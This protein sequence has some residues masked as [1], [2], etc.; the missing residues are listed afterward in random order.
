MEK[1]IGRSRSIA[2]AGKTLEA[3]FA[4]HRSGTGPGLLLLADEAGL[5]AGIRARAG[6][7]GEEGYAVL[8]V[9]GLSEAGEVRA[10][11]DALRAMPEQAGGIGVLGHGAGGAL[12]CR[13]ASAFDAAVAFDPVGL[14]EASEIGAA[15]PALLVFGT[16][17]SAEAEQAAGRI[18]RGLDRSDGSAVLRYPSAAPGFAI[19]HRAGFDKRSD[20]LAHSRALGLLRRALGPHYDLVA[21]FEA[22][23][24]HEFETRDVDATMATM[25]DEPYVNHVPTLAGG[26]GHDMLKR[27]Y[28]YHFVDQN[29]RE[30][31]STPVSETVG[32]DRIVLE[33]VV[34]F[35]HDRVLDRYFPCIAP[36]GKMVEIPTLLLVRF[37][38]D[39]VCHEHIYWDQ[40][41]AL[42][43]IGALDADGLPIAGAEAAAKVLDE[44]RPSNIFMQDAWAESEGKPI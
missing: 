24:R 17:D 26:V 44:T 43:Q 15:C 9:A 14:A 23:V 37:R 18:E 5:D 13:A 10:A 7:F 31:S 12:A 28:K 8:A 2:V 36:T 1:E 4:V 30:R 35:R 32:P 22:H 40:A 41:S 21:L 27:F 25:I 42:S 34:R 33:T 19:P 3:H 11:A 16:R 29:S 20:S 39:R 6:L 38:G